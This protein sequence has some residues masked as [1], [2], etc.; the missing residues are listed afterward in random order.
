MEDIIDLCR[1][2]EYDIVI[3]KLN[4]NSYGP[5]PSQILKYAIDNV[6]IDLIIELFIIDNISPA[7]VHDI[8]INPLLYPTFELLLENNNE[9]C[10]HIS[11][12]V[13]HSDV[14]IHYDEQLLTIIMKYLSMGKLIQNIFNKAITTDNL[15]LID[16]LFKLNYDIKSAFDIMIRTRRYLF[17][18]VPRV[19]FGTF[20]YL[21]TYGVDV[22]SYCK[23]FSIGFC[24]SGDISGLKFCLENGVDVNYILG[25]SIN[26]SIDKFQLLL[27]YGADLNHLTLDNIASCMDRN[28]D[29]VDIFIYLIEHGLDISSYL[30]QLMFRA[31]D[32]DCPCVMKYLIKLGADIHLENDKILFYACKRGS[33]TKCVEILL[34]NGADIRARG[35][36]ILHFVGYGE[37]VQ[38]YMYYSNW[39]NIA[40]ILI[41]AGADICDPVQ[42]FCLYVT[43]L[44]QCQYDEE[45]FTYFLDA[46][47]INFN[48]QIDPALKKNA[49]TVGIKN[50]DLIEYVLELVVYFAPVE[51][52]KL[53]IRYGLDPHIN[54]CGPLKIAIQW[55][56]LK[57]VKILLDC[58]STLD[59]NFES[60]VSSDMIDLLDSYHIAYKL[61]KLID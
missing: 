37:P 4:I 38:S 59:P 3:D 29:N 39:F 20:I 15:K 27:D 57:A 42:I 26:P 14:L 60:D 25:L 45:L 44:T 41:K 54:N 17:S 28:R 33:S 2:F 51:L 56:K 16:M 19:S 21:N 8:M 49:H 61:K 12:I 9:L 53:C 40:K 18:P 43:R 23:I 52:I 50:I 32:N 5:K 46:S 24:Y 7:I 48:T 11:A 1:A 47:D 58:D 35:N 30:N 31:I 6:C 22:I 13:D 10:A 36:H 34:I 55:N